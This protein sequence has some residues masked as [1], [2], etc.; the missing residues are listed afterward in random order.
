MIDLIIDL[1][2]QNGTRDGELNNAME[3]A[4]GKRKSYGGGG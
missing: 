2:G 1:S 3:K 4:V